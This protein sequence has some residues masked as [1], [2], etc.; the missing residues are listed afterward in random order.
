[1]QPIGITEQT[2]KRTNKKQGKWFYN[3]KTPTDSLVSIDAFCCNSIS[4]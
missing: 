1:M 4:N 2:N 3:Y